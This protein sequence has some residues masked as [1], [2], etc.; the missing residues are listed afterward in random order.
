MMSQISCG[1]LLP[2]LD[3]RCGDGTNHGA[4]G[5]LLKIDLQEDGRPL[6]PC[7][8]ADTEG[9]KQRWMEQQAPQRIVESALGGGKNSRWRSIS[10]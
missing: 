2:T 7:G 6:T 10:G 8:A 5:T 1:I 3:F 9:R 4:C